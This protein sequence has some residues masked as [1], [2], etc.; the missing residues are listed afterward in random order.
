MKGKDLIAL[1]KRLGC[2]VVRQKGSHVRIKC[3]TCNTTVP[4][5]AGEDLGKGLLKQ[6]ER[7]LDSC[8]GT[9]WR[10]GK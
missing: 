7:D 5:H 6:I 2:E 1:L 8:L 4:V 9:G 10:K 3:G